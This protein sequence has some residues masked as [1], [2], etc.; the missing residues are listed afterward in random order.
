VLLITSVVLGIGAGLLAGGRIANLASIRFR[1]PLVVLAA[2]IV[3]EVGVIPQFSDSPAIPVLYALSLTVLL[4]WAVWHLRVLPGL[5]L[6]VIG[7]AA[8]SLVVIANAGHMPVRP[9]VGT[10]AE[11]AQ[12]GHVGQYIVAGPDTRLDWLGDWIALPGVLGR[13]F[14]QA[15]SPGDIILAAGLLLA[16]FLAVRRGGRAAEAH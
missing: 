11:L 7:L 10:L 14:P 3:K 4:A 13:V 12:R 6:A 5:W 2:L 1:W 9:G 16:C 15:Y 8:N